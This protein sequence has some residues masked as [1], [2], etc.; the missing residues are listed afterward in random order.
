MVHYLPWAAVQI[1]NKGLFKFTQENGINVEN[2]E[3]GKL[4]EQSRSIAEHY[5]QRF[6]DYMCFNQSQFPEYY[7]NTNDQMSPT[8]NNFFGGWVL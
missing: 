6:I 2:D 5:A 1:S 7:G 4:I 3:V 8:H